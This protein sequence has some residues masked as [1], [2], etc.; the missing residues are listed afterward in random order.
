MEGRFNQDIF[1]YLQ[2]AFKKATNFEPHI[3]TKQT[4]DTRRMN[5]VNQ[6]DVI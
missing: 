6:I 5:E 1:E 2:A 3:L 4:I